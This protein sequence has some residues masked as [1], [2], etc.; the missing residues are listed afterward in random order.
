[1]TAIATGSLVKHNSLGIGKVVAVEATAVHVFFPGS[2]R[3]YAAKLRW[4]AAS[5]LLTI[6][7]VEPDAWLQ[8]LTSFSFDPGAGRYALAANF[9]SHDDAIAEFLE[10][11]PQGFVDPAYLGTNG[12]KRERA[13]RWRAASAEWSQALGGGEG[14]RLLAD[15]DLRELARRALRVGAHVTRILGTLDQDVLAEAL[16]PGDV[17]ATFFEALFG[18]LS[19]PSPTRARFEKLFAASDALGVEPG[20]AWTMATLFPFVAQPERHVLLVPK[21]ACGAATRLGCDLRFTPTPSWGTYAAL[22]SFSAQLLEK[23]RASGARDFI[24]VE[25]FLHATAAR[26]APAAGHDGKASAAGASTPAARG[27]RDGVTTAAPRRKQ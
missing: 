24:D 23:L 21:S 22:R 16:A 4:P 27:R 6:A 8:G 13:P 9:L 11:Y 19:V 25:G 15:G 10:A 20:V 2:E 1:M 26:R 12:G 17:V 5:P 3:R 18:L 14:E 7:G